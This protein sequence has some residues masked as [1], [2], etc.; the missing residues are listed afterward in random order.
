MKDVLLINVDEM[1]LKGR[2]RPFY[3]QSLKLHLKEL[4]KVRFNLSTVINNEHQRL[5]MT[6][7]GV[8]SADV[9]NA[10]RRVPGV[11]SVCLSKSVPLDMPSIEAMVIQLIDQMKPFPRT[12]KV[13]CRRSNKRWPI[14]SMEMNRELG[15]TLLVKFDS[16][17]K[18]LVVDVHRPEVLIDIKVMDECV[19]ISTETLS[20][21]GGLPVGT[22]GHLV[23]LLSGGFDSPVASFL[24]SKRGTKQTFAFFY[25]YPFVGTAVKEKIVKIAS[26]LGEFQKG[27]KLYIIPFGDIQDKIAKHCQEDYRTLLFRRLMI[28][29]TDA[30]AKKIG[31]DAMLTGDSLGQVSSQTIDNLC[32]L[33]KIATKPIL[34]PL[35][36]HNK[37]EIVN[38]SKEVGTHDLSIIPH[39]DACSLFAPK[40][41][42]IRPDLNYLQQFKEEVD[43]SDDIAIA[44]DRAEVHFISVAGESKLL[45]YALD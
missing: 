34:R 14:T 26:V 28:E 42:V 16:G 43:F 22:S 2:N 45:S 20:G 13:M 12:F 3:Y 36:G 21:I 35:V 6:I 40:H 11:H 17:P 1:W 31:A 25:A 38:I 5:T 30:L 32:Y 8:F 19:Y 15:H 18:K 7:D 4:L 39:D 24:M 23:T 9:V 41:P 37:I 27:S 33:D 10:V 44:L 29:C